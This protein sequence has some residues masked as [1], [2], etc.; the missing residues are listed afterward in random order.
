MRRREAGYEGRLIR[1]CGA[2]YK[3]RISRNI[4][5]IVSFNILYIA[6]DMLLYGSIGHIMS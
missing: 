4:A 2:M 6:Q 3:N 1:K 5:F